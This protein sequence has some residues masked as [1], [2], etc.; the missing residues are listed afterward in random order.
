[1]RR[2]PSSLFFRL[3][4]DLQLLVLQAWLTSEGDDRALLHILSTLDIAFCCRAV[5]HAFLSLAAHPALRWQ[6][7]EQI[8][9]QPCDSTWHIKD[10]LGYMGWLHSRG[11]AVK[12]LSLTASGIQNLLSS[13]QTSWLP[14]L[15][16]QTP[17]PPCMLASVEHISTDFLDSMHPKEVQFLLASCP[18]VTS[19][20]VCGS[21]TGVRWPTMA[22]ILS[23]CHVRIKYFCLRGRSAASLTEIAELFGKDLEELLLCYP[24]MV[25]DDGVEAVRQHCKH[26]R[27]LHLD[28]HMVSSI[29]SAFRLFRACKEVNEHMVIDFVCHAWDITAMLTAGLQLRRFA[30]HPVHLGTPRLSL[31]PQL[32]EAHPDW[33]LIKMDQF[34]FDRAAHQL[35]LK[36][37][38]TN[39]TATDLL[40]RILLVCR[41]VLKLDV[42]L[43]HSTGAESQI[44]RIGN[45]VGLTLQELTLSLSIGYDGP[46]AVGIALQCS[47]LVRLTI[48][49][50]VLV[51]G[52]LEQVAL[53]CPKLQYLCIQD[54]YKP[55][56]PLA[57][58]AGIEA[59]IACCQYMK[60]LHIDNGIRLTNRVL[61]AI[62]HHKRKLE[63]L[64]WQQ[65]GFQ[66]DDVDV[67]RE[68][69]R[70]L[71]LLPV[72]VLIGE[73]QSDALFHLSMLPKLTDVVGD[74]CIC[75]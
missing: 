43:C 56:E 71:Q 47:Q 40:D 15:F 31:F 22:P 70:L 17:T 64:S 7:R 69:A 14:A 50:L 74:G 3:P 36:T 49:D 4:D 51:E 62:L 55:V 39:V 68:H 28:L 24:T 67:F 37:S 9:T 20:E 5:R 48:I 29:E 42:V 12:A 38:T 60:H 59:I 2:R 72:P 13:Q 30:W 26:L 46:S 1:M 75:S 16:Q 18:N 8:M 45:A 25:T 73:L 10:M 54:H 61:V 6:S 33:T 58:D 21:Y 23:A 11:V 34:S 27:L 32:L 44:T 19:L 63:T 57:W 41:P 66:Q 65:I 53:H 35:T 52:D